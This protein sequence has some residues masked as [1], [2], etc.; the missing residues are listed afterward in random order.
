MLAEIIAF[1]AWT[2]KVRTPGFINCGGDRFRHTLALG[3]HT[4]MLNT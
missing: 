3:E 4:T 2:A 1:N